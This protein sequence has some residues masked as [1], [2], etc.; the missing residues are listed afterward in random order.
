MTNHASSIDPQEQSWLLFGVFLRDYE[1]KQLLSLTWVPL[2]EADQARME[3]FFRNT[4]SRHRQM[5]AKTAVHEKRMHLLKCTLPK[6]LRFAAVFIAVLAVSL[7]IAM[8]AIPELMIYI[9]RLFS[10]RTPE[11]SVITMDPEIVYHIPSEWNGKLFPTYCPGGM[12]PIL[13]HIDPKGDSY[14]LYGDDL[15]AAHDRKQYSFI[16]HEINLKFYAQ[17]YT[18]DAEVRVINMNGHP[19]SVAQKSDGR[20]LVWWNDDETL[21]LT[22]SLNRTLEDTL[23]FVEYLRPVSDIA[24]SLPVSERDG[25][26]Q[27]SAKTQEAMMPENWTGKNILTNLPETAVIVDYD[28]D[29]CSL[30]YYKLNPDENSSSSA[31]DICYSEYPGTVA[32]RIDTEGAE[33]SAHDINGSSVTAAAK[34]DL[35]SLWWNDEDTMFIFQGQSLTLPE[36]LEYARNIVPANSP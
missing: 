31:W 5:I 24:Q 21:F 2:C 8:A 23:V 27:P 1:A 22:E 7:G 4:E 9:G 10:V 26:I 35:V 19:V 29:G 6:A 16:Y 34:D 30:V 17:N 11:Y 3:S 14:L 28:L 36:M 15:K 25:Q 18:E 12:A 20:I 13:W 32:I 33:L